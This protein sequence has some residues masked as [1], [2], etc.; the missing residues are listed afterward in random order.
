MLKIFKRTKEDEVYSPVAGTCIK[1]EDVKDQMFA[2][3]LLGDGI[4]ILPSK[5]TIYAPIDGQLIM[6]ANTKHAFGIKNKRGLEILVHVG[7]DSV[8]LK[9]KGFT[10]YKE[11]H[12]HVRKGEA[13]LSFDQALFEQE[14]IDMTVLIIIK[15]GRA[16]V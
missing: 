1:I 8:K 5:E 14:Q 10:V 7:L 16:H 2:N 4:A 12:E 13:I 6:L 3:K 11:L 9:G 15:I